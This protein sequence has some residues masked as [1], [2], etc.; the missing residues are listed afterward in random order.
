MNC[1]SHFLY[2]L[3]PENL[4]HLGKKQFE[5]FNFRKRIAFACGFEVCSKFVAY[6]EI[7][8][9]VHLTTFFI[10]KSKGSSY[11]SVCL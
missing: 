11:M 8:R 4:D 2:M 5:Y 6:K 1:I 10:K 7:K 9:Y 3:L